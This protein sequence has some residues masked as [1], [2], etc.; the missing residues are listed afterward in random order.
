ME[1]INKIY[2]K[3]CKFLISSGQKIDALN[4]DHSTNIINEDTWLEK[5]FSSYISLPKEINKNNNCSFFKKREKGKPLAIKDT[6]PELKN[7]IN[8][9]E[10]QIKK[11]KKENDKCGDALWHFEHP[12]SCV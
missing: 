9:L 11:L 2:C 1:K 6:I 7:K 4:C 3:E 10:I 8:K 12:G 5:T